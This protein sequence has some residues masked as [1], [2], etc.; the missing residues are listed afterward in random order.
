[1]LSRSYVRVSFMKHPSSPCRPEHILN[2][3]GIHPC[4]SCQQKSSFESL[5]S[6]HPDAIILDALFCLFVKFKPHAKVRASRYQA[7]AASDLF[8]GKSLEMAARCEGPGITAGRRCPCACQISLPTSLHEHCSAIDLK[9]AKGPAC[10]SVSNL[11][12]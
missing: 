9:R 11:K 5:E 4:R 10:S 1:M 3:N 6:H 8:G 2:D 7:N 12:M